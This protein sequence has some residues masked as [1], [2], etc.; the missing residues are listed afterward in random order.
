MSAFRRFSWRPLLLVGVLEVLGADDGVG[1]DAPSC[2]VLDTDDV[3]E[4]SL[5]ELRA[6]WPPALLGRAATPTIFELFFKK[7]NF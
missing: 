1:V 6:D 3:T 7:R 4:E 2:P 5:E